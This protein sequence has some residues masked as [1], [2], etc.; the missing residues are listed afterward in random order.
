MHNVSLRWALEDVNLFSP[1]KDTLLML[2]CFCSHAEP[3]QHDHNG[4]NIN[5]YLCQSRRADPKSPLNYSGG[6]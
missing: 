5:T 3:S 6:T 2:T 1:S 4:D